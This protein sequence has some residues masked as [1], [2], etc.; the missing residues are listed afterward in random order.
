M[1]DITLDELNRSDAS[2][3]VTRLA[4]VYEH[5]P[6]AAERAFAARPFATVAA[7]HA[8]MHAAVRAA[9]D[10]ERSALIKAHP[11]LAG[12]AAR[13]GALT[14]ESTSEQLTAGL[15]RL[16]EEEFDAFHR[17]NTAYREKFDI[18]FIVSVRR[19]TKDSI[20][21]SFERRLMH[22][23]AAERATALAEID[24]I[25]ALRLESLVAGDGSLRLDGRLSTHVLDTHLGRP[26]TGVAIELRE[27]SRRNAPR[28]IARAVTNADGRTDAPLIAGRP[29]PIGSYELIFAVGDYF[30]SRGVTLSDP[31]FL[32]LVPLRFG[33]AEAEG[34]YHV[35][36]VMTPWSFSTYRGS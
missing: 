16:S 24:R 25:A 13:A 32:D 28:T 15:D 4:N 3:F 19:H 8:A 21:A 18:P 10:G 2:S 5:A 17:L 22:D 31:P 29:V 23:A 34:N 14:A 6:W 7:L 36:L 1:A 26:A 35:P 12:K 30:K 20:I 11:D 9:S 27:L 33:I